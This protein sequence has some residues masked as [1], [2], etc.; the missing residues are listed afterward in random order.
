MFIWTIGLGIPFHI[1]TNQYRSLWTFVKKVSSLFLFMIN[2]LI[3]LLFLYVILPAIHKSLVI[4]N[5]DSCFHPSRSCNLILPYIYPFIEIMM[6]VL[7][8]TILVLIN[9]GHFFI[10]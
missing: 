8:E 3:L 4:N 10:Y 1:Q 9:K 7:N 6:I 5:D 2:Y